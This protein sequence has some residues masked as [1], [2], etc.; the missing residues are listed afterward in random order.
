MRFQNAIGL[1]GL[2]VTN[3][4]SQAATLLPF[5]IVG[6]LDAYGNMDTSDCRDP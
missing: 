6:G 3:V 4:A 5:N 1:L 2:F